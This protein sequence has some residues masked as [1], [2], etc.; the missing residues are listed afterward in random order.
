MRRILLI[1]VVGCLLSVISFQKTFSL[2]RHCTTA[3]LHHRTTRPP[4][5]LAVGNWQLVVDN[6]DSLW[7]A[8]DSLSAAGLPNSA[9]AVVDHIYN[10]AKAS[11]DDPQLVKAILFR[12]SL[13]ST[14]Q[15]DVPLESIRDVRKEIKTSHPP[16]TQIL[17]SILG[18]LFDSYYLR[19]QYRFNNRTALAGSIQENPETWDAKRFLYEI[20]LNYRQS[21]SDETMLQ[22]IPL[23]RY[24]A[25][26]EDP[27]ADLEKKERLSL[28]PST[29]FDFLSQRALQFFTRREIPIIRPSA[30]FALDHSAFFAQTPVF[31]DY[32]LKPKGIYTRPGDGTFIP[33]G[34]DTLSLTW[35]ATRIYQVL[36]G[37]H[38]NNKNP[39]ALIYWELQRF[40]YVHQASTLPGKDSLYFAALRKFEQDYRFS[41]ASTE[42]SFTLA[43]ALMN[44]GEKYDP[45]VSEAYRWELADALK[46][47]TDAA[48]RFPASIGGKNCQSLIK[49]ILAPSL[50]VSAEY[51]IIP[52]QPALASLSFK[53]IPSLNFRL[54]K[55]DP[56][57]DK[58]ALS[59]L[60]QEEVFN[61]L[62]T[63]ESINQWQVN[64]PVTG[65][66]QNHR[67]EID[68]PPVYPGYYFLFASADSLFRNPSVPFSY[69]AVWS[70]GISYITQRNTL[71]GIDIYLL[72]RITGCP[73]KKIFSEVFSRS[74]DSRT[75]QYM[76]TKTG[77]FQSDE[78][79]F[80]T[81]PPPQGRGLH[82]NLFISI[83]N[84][85]DLLISQPLYVYPA[86]DQQVK[87]VEQT[88]FLTDRAIYRP[89]QPVYFKGI[90]LE[91][92]GDSTSLKVAKKTLVTFTD[93]NGQK[94]IDQWFT[95]DDYGSF[96]GSFT[97]PSG[98]LMGDMR[99][100]NESGSVAIA[101]EEYKRP[102]F[103]VLLNPVEGNYRL[104]EKVNITGK[105][106]GY[107]GNAIDAGTVSYRVVRTASYPY[108]RES[109]RLPFPSSPE[110]EI[111]NGTL[112]TAKDG[113]F[114]IPFTA[115][116]DNSISPASQPVFTFQV[117][118]AVTDLNGES[119]SAQESVSVGYT[120]LLINLSLPEKLNLKSNGT[121]ALTTTNL[122]GKS[123]P[124]EVQLTLQKLS[125]PSR[126]FKSR[127]WDQPDTMI[128]SMD[129]FYKQFPNDIYGDDDNPGSWPAQKELFR[130]HLNTSNDTLICL[131]DTRSQIPDKKNQDSQSGIRHPASGTW[132]P[133]SAI[134][135][136]GSY[137][138]ILSATDPFGQKVEKVLY[139]TAFDPEAK[140]IPVP[141]MN[142]FIPVKSSGEPGE[143]ASFL[144]GTSEKEVH[145]I[146]EIR[147]KDQLYSR[148]WF[149]LKNQQKVVE[150]PILE[151]FRG[152]FS[153]NFLFVCQNRVFQSS[154]LVSV[155]YSNKKLDID[156]ETFRNRLVP[157]QQ[158]E[159]KIR[160]TNASGNGIPAAL[161][162][163]MYDRSL[164]L[165]RSNNWS[166]DLFKSYFYGVPW[167]VN[168]DFR[169]TSDSWYASWLNALDFLY[170]NPYK[171]NWFGMQLPEYAPLWRGGP[172]RGGPLKN[173]EVFFM[174]A[175]PRMAGM[176]KPL[177]PPMD[178]M[179]PV[180]NRE[181]PSGIPDQSAGNMQSPVFPIRK[182]FR[183]TA[184]F[185]P[186]I[187]SD[188]SGNLFLKFTVPEVLTSWKLLGLAYTKKLD[189]GLVEK[190]LVTQKDLMIFP[191]VP[192]FV[193][194]GDTVVFI[195]RIVNL[196]NQEISGEAWLN[197]E[198]A[199][200]MQPLNSLILD[201]QYG[202]LD[203]ENFHRA[204]Q[205]ADRRSYT[206]SAGQSMA[207]SWALAIPVSTFISLLQY[208]I[209]AQS[210][211]FSDGEQNII[212]VLTNRMMVTESLP[213][214][215]KG[216][217]TISF[218]FDKLLQSANQKSLSNS[219]LTLEF[220]SNPAWYALQALPALEVKTYRNS[221]QIFSACY[222]NLLASHI[223]GSNSRIR[224]ILESWKSLTPDALL[225]NLGKKEELKSAILQET[226]WVLDAVNESENRR[227]LG[228]YFDMNN[229]RQNI[230]ENFKLLQQMQYPSGGWPW[231]DG[232]RENRIVTLNILTGFGRLEHLGVQYA[233]GR[234]QVA[235]MIQ[236]A[237][238]YLDNELVQDYEQ[239]KKNSPGKLDENHLMPVQVKYLY[240]RSLIHP[241]SDG[242][243]RN[244]PGSGIR[245][246]ETGISQAIEYYSAQARKFWLKQDLASQGMIALA[247]YHMGEDV[248]PGRIMKSLS[249]KALRSP[250]LGMYWASRDGYE[251]YQAPVEAQALMI[252]AYDEVAGDQKSVEELK[253]WLLK[254]KQT[255]M[256]RTKQA[257]VDA[258]YALL[259]KGS[260]LLAG[261]P[262]IQ[263][264]VGDKEIDPSRMP[265][266][267]QEAGTGY[268]SMSW[269]GDAVTPDM[270]NITI[271]KSTD[272][273]AWG[274]LYWQYFENLDQITPHETPLA[275]EKEI[276]LEQNTEAG[277]ILIS[278]KINDLR[279]GMN[280]SSA[281]P[282]TTDSL[283]HHDTIAPRHPI[284]IGDKLITRLIIT[285]DRNMEF[286]HLKDMRAAG[287]EPY[288]EPSSP[289]HSIT[290]SPL[291]GYRYQD[292]LG[293]YQSTTD[294]ATNFFFDYLPKGAW[295][296][297]YPLVVNNAG[298]FS[299]GIATIQCMYAP[300]FS[301]HSE[302]SRIE[303]Q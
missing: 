45:L 22:E 299:T 223:A 108:W 30:T 251:W 182:N 191:N 135:D 87:P 84:G 65:D 276:F 172:K 55:A 73:L 33:A 119:R 162:A 287:L 98:V 81:I 171:I 40:T 183:E 214:P 222:A 301:A 54:I 60:K 142:W 83:H 179:E 300:E 57:A 102:T 78:S 152:N 134:Q 235:E 253:I 15:E 70:T 71:G 156:I 20:I 29:L 202:I 72:N 153:V 34:T 245:D 161:L 220:A 213:L 126:A 89:G 259:L 92:T 173:R 13:N 122:S 238:A 59:G 204:S 217:G 169:T 272:G 35:Y 186:S 14:F 96:N 99:I 236:K 234:E 94:I 221:D 227:K 117:F 203:T 77:E 195:A 43:Q 286:V 224:Q 25:I 255:Q 63:L 116:P 273:I 52:D 2:P 187:L 143:T 261:G 230:R 160:I 97:A 64:L 188:S 48:K 146:R 91:R 113:T 293:Y 32:P 288:M 176:Q 109:W 104:G 246:P 18:E 285:V 42:I 125:G 129:A 177:P 131:S 207:V 28:I 291:S 90:V 66:Y 178:E 115:L 120:S 271:T 275:V 257:T 233:E 105:A 266:L 82:S 58:N 237:I 74:Y 289:H 132:H 123:T 49:K 46:V 180:V 158:E 67:T 185:Y 139:F 93:A 205:I 232:M 252:E 239:L 211:D 196:S 262:Q 148:E 31:I 137:R 240:A 192:R 167:E 218:A 106:T 280:R 86:A 244:D 298:D 8:A 189:Y 16:V 6:Y 212:P 144:I 68:I 21:L 1:L 56:E 140:R 294:L 159:W 292:G 254:Q 163:T 256:W 248:T 277:P 9:L 75:R 128:L 250:E 145:V 85:D 281:K 279:S 111:T 194:Q 303:I 110:V 149:T 243:A 154:Q 219:R 51:A 168:D 231:F 268:F 79:G 200:T 206:I 3:T 41:P 278:L 133:A 247:L 184:F 296:F 297:E 107:A 24:R 228:L 112:L 157:G 27:S 263:V 197:L 50:T 283:I 121:F 190:E 208:T 61:Y 38:L 258:C 69:Q 26:L 165:F 260:D 267:K 103:E 274:G 164:D 114:T 7:H 5:Q 226:P 282:I 4:Y 181:N 225:S 241:A 265:D 199:I 209:T 201:T 118:T 141:A 127:L 147:V 37:F 100:F 62:S 76:L 138:L 198:E 88:R 229:L 150:I 44:E 175:E 270:G 269:M 12:I 302:G 36:A 10:Q 39:E 17:Y 23:E 210:G 216:K 19:N 80:F 193:R 11:S 166:F 284:A 249:E 264:R 174:E 124:A 151:E 170:R 242:A 47:C 130:V 155:P 290:S 101:V 295:V 215:V 136:P 53:N 95:T